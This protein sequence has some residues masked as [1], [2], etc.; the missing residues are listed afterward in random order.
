MEL[1]N[2]SSEFIRVVSSQDFVSQTV[3]QVIFEAVKS[4][5]KTSQK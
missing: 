2:S 1:L 3:S 5:S 4:M